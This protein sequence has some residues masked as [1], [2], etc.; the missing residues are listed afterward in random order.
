MPPVRVRTLSDVSV[1]FG[2]GDMALVRGPSGSGKSTLLAVLGGLLTADEGR[3]LLDD[4]CVSALGGLS[5]P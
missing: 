3:V 4:V 1:S 2:S 5:L